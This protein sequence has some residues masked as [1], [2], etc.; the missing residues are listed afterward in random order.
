MDAESQ[1]NGQA[2]IQAN[3]RAHPRH[4][5]ETSVLLHMIDVGAR[6]S[7]RVLNLSLGG[8]LIRTDDSFPTGIFRKIE[9]E[10]SV[11]GI[12]FRLPGVTQNIRERRFVGIRFLNLSDRKQ[13]QLLRLMREIEQSNAPDDSQ[14][15]DG[16]ATRP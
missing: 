15:A 9:A 10:F 2:N 12:P 11:D 16:R 1:T 8:C 7:G 13:E 6:L 14:S 5:V 3:R 4:P